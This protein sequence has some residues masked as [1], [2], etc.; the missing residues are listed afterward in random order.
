MQNTMEQSLVGE[1]F[2]EELIESVT[3]DPEEG[4][5]TGGVPAQRQTANSNTGGI[6]RHGI[7]SG[8]RWDHI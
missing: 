3:T 6:S 8:R 7:N 1:G 5:G 2:L 4:E